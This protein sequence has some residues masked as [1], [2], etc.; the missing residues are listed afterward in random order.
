MSQFIPINTRT[1]RVKN[2]FAQRKWISPLR[3][4]DLKYRSKYI[5]RL[6]KKLIFP[7]WRSCLFS[8][9]SGLLEDKK[10]RGIYMYRLTSLRHLSTNQKYMKLPH[11]FSQMTNTYNRFLV[12]RAQNE[13]ILG[14]S[15]P[16]VRT[17]QWEKSLR[18]FWEIWYGYY[19]TGGYPNPYFLFVYNQ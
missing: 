19:V 8:S 14:W 11:L 17:F 13:P 7:W 5:M 12:R 4:G 6:K 18:D 15:C 3:D 16:I 10:G 1:L 2:L 9:V